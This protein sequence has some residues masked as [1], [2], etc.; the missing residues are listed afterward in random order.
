MSSVNLIH[1][2]IKAGFDWNE[3]AGNQKAKS[4]GGNKPAIESNLNSI[5][6]IYFQ[7]IHEMN[8]QLRM[9]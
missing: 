3:M 7:D 6:W 2:L 1:S 8:N 5:S 4:G 9:N